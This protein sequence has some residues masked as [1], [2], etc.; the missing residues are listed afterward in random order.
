MK[1]TLL[2]AASFLCCFQSIYAFSFSTDSLFTKQIQKG[3]LV[4]PSMVEASGLAVSRSN[5]G[6]LWAH[7]DSGDK[8]RLFLISES[9]EL[10]LTVTLKGAKNVDWEDI[11]SFQK[12][13]KNYICVGD[14]GDN[15]AIRKE[16]TLYMFEEPIWNGQSQTLEVD[17]FE[18]MSFTYAEGARDAETL[19]VDPNNQDIVIL[20]KRDPQALV[21]Q[22]KFQPGK[23]FVIEKSGIMKIT[24]F[25]AGD[26]N[27]KGEIIIKDYN[28]IYLYKSGGQSV[29]SILINGQFIKI[30]YKP[31][32][33]GESIVWSLDCTGFFTVSEKRYEDSRQ[34]IYFFT[35]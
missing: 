20:S 6:L 14:I 12:D 25:T 11:T 27:V 34:F 29:S 19:M 3:E 26:V 2:I 33:Q 9:G 8:P 21:Y 4:D 13:G 31:E 15:R 22:F 10:K 35:N 24:G 7:N 28:N 32:P 18:S 23:D 1:K 16:L 5:D 17:Q 30:P